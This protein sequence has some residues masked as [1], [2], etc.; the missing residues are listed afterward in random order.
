MKKEFTLKIF[1][2]FSIERWND[3]VRPFEI[4]EMDK[5][6]EKTVVAYIIAKYEEN[7]GAKIDWEWLIYASLFDLLRKI[8]LC[9]IKSPV[10]TLIKN[11]YPEEYARLNDWV[12]ERY[13]DLIDDKEL[14][15]KFEFYLKDL[16]SFS[17]EKKE[18]PLT[19][20]IFRAAHKY[21]TLRELEMIS[22][23]NET[24]RLDSIR[25]ELNADLQKYLDLRGLQLLITKQKPFEFLMRIEQLRFQTR[26]NQT[27]RVPRTSVLGHC[28]FVAILTLLLCRDSGVKMCAKRLYNNFFS[29]LFHDLP[30]SVTRDI[31][32]PVKR[33][34]DGLPAI[35]KDIEDKIV[36]KELVPLM[37]KFYCD[38][39]L[40]F[41]SDE[42]M[43]RCVFDGCVLP[44]SFEEL[45]SAFNEDK[46][47]PVDGRLVRVADHY[48][49]L[50]E[51]GLSIRYGITSQQLTDG[52]ANLLKVYDDGK[53]INGI[54]AKKLFHEFID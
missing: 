53:V 8:Q 36:S 19:V 47:N 10:Q 4:I 28:F 25:K 29:G 3:L 42:F 44:V 17:A 24:E 23:V 21:S 13:K 2:A 38:E 5:H 51:A 39:I 11:E 26:W 27:P 18:L 37:E 1:E 15:K 20:K 46:Y 45:N 43:N 40:Y 41:T 33:A 31:I 50:L 6:A 49:A 12:L 14:Y 32:S 9:D 35:V 34:T 48:S 7:L 16:S 22:P 54:D 30:E 52:K